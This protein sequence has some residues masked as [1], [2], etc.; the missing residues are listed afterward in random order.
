MTQ[1]SA[2]RIIPARAG[3]TRNRP[4][5]SAGW[6]DHPRSR[7]VYPTW[8]CGRPGTL[9]SSPLAR[10]LRRTK[11]RRK[12][13]GRIIPARAGFTPVPARPEG[14]RRDHPR[15][16]GVYLRPRRR[17]R[18][19]PGS[20]PLAR[21][22]LTRGTRPSRV[23]RIIPA[24]AGFTVPR[25]RPSRLDGD[26][27]RSR[28]V[29]VRSCQRPPAF[30]GSSPL[31]RGLRYGNR[32]NERNLRIIPAR[33]GF[34]ASQCKH[35]RWAGDHPRSRGVYASMSAQHRLCCGSSPLARG[36]RLHLLSDRVIR[37]IIPARAGFTR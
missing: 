21:G 15:S 11:F 2:M 3:F 5:G 23:T 33:A 8:R 25:V 18:P 32:S 19:A 4:R 27:P 34:T 30:S 6:P 9:G 10:G 17:R 28:G 16:R 14:P 31:A 35:T 12:P 1:S 37:R 7:G 24:R 22:L 36:L 26:H 29:Y 20:S 13:E